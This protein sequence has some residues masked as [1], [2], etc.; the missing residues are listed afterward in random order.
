MAKYQEAISGCMFVKKTKLFNTHQLQE[1]E[2]KETLEQ[3]YANKIKEKSSNMILEK[4]MC[5]NFPTSEIYKI[6]MSYIY[7]MLYILD[8]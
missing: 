5:L 6:P 3:L 2:L 1:T 7:S 4:C 8:I